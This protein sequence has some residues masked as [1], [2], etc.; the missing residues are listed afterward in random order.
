MQRSEERRGSRQI[1][2]G[3]RDTGLERESMIVVRCDIKNLSKPSLRFGEATKPHIGKRVL[4]EVHAT[5]K[6]AVGDGSPHRNDK[7]I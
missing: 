3:L 4:G 1:A 2:L 7:M 6:T 5:S